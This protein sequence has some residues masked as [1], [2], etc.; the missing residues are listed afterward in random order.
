M[1][2]HVHAAVSAARAVIYSDLDGTLVD[3]K[4]FEPG[5]EVVEHVKELAKNHVLVIPVTSKT[6][7]EVTRLRGSLP[8][9]PLAIVE[10]GGALVIDWESPELLGPPR[11]TLVR[12]VEQLQQEGWPVTGLSQMDEATVSRVSGLSMAGAARAMDRVASEPFIIHEDAEVDTDALRRRVVELGASVVRGDR[13]WHVLGAGLGKGAAV[14]MLEARYP[15]LRSL[16]RAGIGDAWNDIDMLCF[17]D[18]G[19][20][21]G[22]L[23]ARQDVPCSLARIVEMGPAGFVQAVQ[24]F[25]AELNL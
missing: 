22:T 8:L 13:F 18:H 14:K 1:H 12:V 24:R 20:L 7:P 25:R 10:G 9:A 21:L 15:H 3:A 2:D 11:A 16:P 4:T 23:V 19:F 6:V 5:S 17:V